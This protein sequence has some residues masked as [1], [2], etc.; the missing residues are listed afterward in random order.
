M[1]DRISTLASVLV[2]T[3]IISVC[4]NAANSQVVTDGLVGYWTFDED[5]IEG[6][7]AKDVWADND[8]AIVGNAIMVEG[9]VGGAL[10]FDGVGSYVEVP[11]HESLQL[12]EKHTLEAWIYQ[13]ESRSSRIIDK[14]GAGTANGPHLD[15]HPGTNLRSCA[16]NCIS[17][18]VTYTLEEWHHVAVTFDDG[19]VKLYLDGSVEGEG[20]VGS[21]LAGNTLTL[22]VAADSNGQNLFRGIIDEVRVYNQALSE[23]E[24]N[25]N[26]KAEGLAVEGPTDKLTVTWGE[27]KTL[28]FG[29]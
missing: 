7:T 2:V 5:D 13:M 28:D 12:W 25:Q 27:M 1:S 16:G 10:E 9:K 24:I 19:E 29:E 4:A 20:A 3:V 8:G 17:T 26:M 21:P 6:E 14:I 23:E 18:A 15:T 11:D 22:K